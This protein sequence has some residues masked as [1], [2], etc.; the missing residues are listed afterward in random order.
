LRPI[1]TLKTNDVGVNECFF[2][3][4][5]LFRMLFSLTLDWNDRTKPEKNFSFGLIMGFG[6]NFF[7]LLEDMNV[8]YKV[9]RMFFFLG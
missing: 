6:A 2:Y 5:S 9:F 7:L 8:F 4:D 1:P 3:E